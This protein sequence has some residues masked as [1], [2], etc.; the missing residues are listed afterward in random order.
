MGSIV[1]LSRRSVSRQVP[2]ASV[3]A[4]EAREA[5]TALLILIGALTVAALAMSAA[6]IA[7]EAN[8]WNDVRVMSAFVMV[9]ALLKVGLANALFYVMMR[10]DEASEA[11][12]PARARALAILR[13]PL[14]RPLGLRKPLTR[15]PARSGDTGKLTLVPAAKP[16]ARPADR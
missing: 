9:F 16:G 12:A 14:A 6:V 7:T 5:K 1:Q 10:A 3:A 11:A 2:D 8:T 15:K 4:T 13:R